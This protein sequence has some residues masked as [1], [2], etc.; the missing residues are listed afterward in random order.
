MRR[1][2]ILY[3]ARV[4]PEQYSN[5]LTDSQ[6]SQLHKSILYV[7]STAV[8]LLA[9][10]ERFPEEWLFK[11]RWGKGKKDQKQTLP[12]GDKIVYLTVGGRTSAVVPS[13]QKK[14]GPVAADVDATNS[15]TNLKANKNKEEDVYEE[16]SKKR[17]VDVKSTVDEPSVHPDADSGPENARKRRGKKADTKAEPFKAS[18]GQTRKSAADTKAAS[19]AKKEKQNGGRKEANNVEPGNP[20]SGP[21][22]S[23]RVTRDRG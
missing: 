19:S 14:T 3:N 21:R 12:N 7:C 10:S 13:V 20:T 1:D 8:D 17:K 18:V 11:H 6:L 22:R 16:S 15:T 2:E 5:T 23:S 4:H 9:D